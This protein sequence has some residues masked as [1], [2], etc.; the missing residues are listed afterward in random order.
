MEVWKK[1]PGFDRYEASSLGRLRSINYKNSGQIKLLKPGLSAGYLK[2]MLLADDG[3][4]KSWGVHKFIAI[5]FIGPRPEG[6]EINHK[7][8]IKLDNRA[9]ELE[10]ITHA[11]NVQ[12][13]FD[14]DLTLPARGSNNGNS[15]L[16]EQ[17]VIEIRNRAAN[18]GRFYGRTALAKKYN[19]SIG[20]IKE[21]VIRR[22]NIW[23]HV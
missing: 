19:V 20:C 6:K 21:V 1:I 3:K 2:T 16:T 5:T 18:N 23:A 12:H 7:K 13:A 11:K 10:Y 4:Y 14:N 8:G 15:I 17:Q 9:K 22:R